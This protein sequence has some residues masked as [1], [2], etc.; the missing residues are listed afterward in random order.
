MSVVTSEPSGEPGGPLEPTRTPPNVRL[1]AVAVALAIVVLGVLAFFTMRS[2]SDET[3]ENGGWAGTLLG[4]PL[5]KPQ[6]TLTDTSGN[7]YD[8]A[9]QTDGYVTLLYF[10]YTSC[11]DVCPLLTTR[12]SG[13]RTQ[14]APV[15]SSVRFVSFS[16]DPGNDRPDVLKQYVQKHGAD[17]P[18]WSFLTG[19]VDE[20][21]QV[22][23]D[24]FKQTLEASEDEAGKAAGILHGSHFVLVDRNLD[25]RG[26]YPSDEEGTLRLARDARILVAEKKP[27]GSS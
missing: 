10:G 13:V 9:Q 19:P 24:G 2:E 5:D 18:D 15:R 20:M 27:R 16:V 11:P 21:K 4:Q 1:V 6:F 7:S 12:M 14:L 25:I 17:Q 23:I 3:D 26:F 22:V 8:F